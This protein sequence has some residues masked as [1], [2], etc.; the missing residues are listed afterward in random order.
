MKTDVANIITIKSTIEGKATFSEFTRFAGT[1][2]GELIGTEN[3][4]IVLEKDAVIEGKIFCESII[5]DG[6]V[7]GEINATKKI[8]ISNTGRVFGNIFAPTIQVDF[9]AL[10][11]GN[12]KTIDL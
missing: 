11:E 2:K 10:F 5:I 4:V 12:A 7:R 8:Y 6:F 1:L 3:S 9:G